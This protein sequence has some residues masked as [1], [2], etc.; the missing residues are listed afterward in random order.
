VKVRQPK[1]KYSSD[2]LL[3]PPSISTPRADYNSDEYSAMLT[4][5]KLH[6]EDDFKEPVKPKKT[7][8]PAV[9]SR[10]FKPQVCKHETPKMPRTYKDAIND[11]KSFMTRIKR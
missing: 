2:T 4:G 3:G 1:I 5:G 6:I 9:K 11:A 10:L 8:K 7:P